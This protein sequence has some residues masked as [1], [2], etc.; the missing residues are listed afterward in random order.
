MP[1][2][3]PALNDRSKL[4]DLSGKAIPTNR[5]E[6]ARSGDGALSAAGRSRSEPAPFG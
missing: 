2:A 6:C 4:T 3:E 1:K 5:A